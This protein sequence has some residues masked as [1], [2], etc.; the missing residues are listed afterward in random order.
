MSK[1]VE[2][3]RRKDA[4]SYTFQFFGCK[5]VMMSIDGK[6]YVYEPVLMRLAKTVANYTQPTY[7]LYRDLHKAASARDIHGVRAVC[8]E[9]FND[10]NFLCKINV[11][12][13]EGANALFIEDSL[14]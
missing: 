13:A 5:D 4:V 10:E 9:D 11:S 6:T 12:E 3:K 2:K 7:S 1:L 8:I 14:K